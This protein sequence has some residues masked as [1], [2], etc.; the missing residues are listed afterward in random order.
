[1]KNSAH[2]L[3]VED[4]TNVWSDLTEMFKVE[5]DN[6]ILTLDFAATAKEGL[7]K[8]NANFDQTDL[9]IIDVILPDLPSNDELYFINSLKNKIKINSHQ[10]KPQGILVSAHKSLTALKTIASQNEWIV[11]FLVKPLKRKSFRQAIE[12]TLNFSLTSN[13]YVDNHHGVTEDL[14][15]EFRQEAKIIK[16]KM[17]RSVQDILDAGKRLH[18]VKEKLPHGYFKN[19]IETELGCHY[20][21]GVNLMRVAHVFGNNEEKIT[22]MGIGPSILYFLATPSTPKQAREKVIQLIEDGEKVSFAETKKIV[23]EYRKNKDKD[24]ANTIAKAD[25]QPQPLI[26]NGEKSLASPVNQLAS[27]PE[28]PIVLPKQQILKVIPQKSE[29]RVNSQLNS[30]EKPWQKLGTHWLINDY[31]DSESFRKYL[32]NSISLT[33]AFPSS[34]EWSKEKIIPPQSQSISILYSP[35]KELDIFPLLTIVRNTIELYTG[36]NDHVIF[37]FLPYPELILIAESLGCKCI[38]AEPDLQQYQRV[39]SFWQDH[40]ARKKM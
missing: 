17:K 14:V 12:K 30:P 1:M 27:A 8:V 24:N 33:I 38:I 25:A 29:P 6:Q 21:T 37:S 11:N 39:L 40:Q 5:L 16:M 13:T 23:R 18:A 20:T 2:I 3:V 34:L 22:K 28:K 19:W 4:H 15:K 32:P 35:F 10:K 31:P 36:E 9:V 7:E 26:N